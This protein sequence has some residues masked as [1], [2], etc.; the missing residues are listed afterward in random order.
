LTPR[1]K[2]VLYRAR[3]K[4]SVL[5]ALIIRE[6]CARFGRSWGG[7]LW[8]LAEPVGGILLF[9][10]A[11]SYIARTPPIGTSFIFFYASGIIPFL[12]YNSVANA[13]MQ[14]IRANRGLLTYPVVTPLDTLIARALLEMVTHFALATILFT[15]L[16]VLEAPR[17]NIE[18]VALATA[19]LMACGL[20]IGV[21]T[22]NCV[23]TGFLP[24]WQNVWSVL[25]RP[26]FLIS[27]VLFTFDSLPTALRNALWFNPVAHVVVETR[28]GLYGVQT[29]GFTSPLYVFGTGMALFVIGAFL[30]KRNEG[31]LL[32]A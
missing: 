24:T 31:R 15:L 7:Y 23:L 10:I 1:L 16:A 6:T 26:L 21:G 3:R 22:L 30:L 13:A 19:F 9:A 4:A 27:G 11:F 17:L 5:A 2:S 18:P 28:Y 20:G 14:A 32:N 8:A 29:P 12:T 25:N